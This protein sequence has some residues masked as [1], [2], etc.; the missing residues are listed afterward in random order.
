MDNKNILIN[1]QSNFILNMQLLDTHSITL[2]SHI[3]TNIS[4]HP[5]S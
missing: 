1:V 2:V 5:N 3:D 4:F